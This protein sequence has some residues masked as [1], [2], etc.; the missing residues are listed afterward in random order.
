MVVW[1][2]FLSLFVLVSFVGACTNNNAGQLGTLHLTDISTPISPF[3]SVEYPVGGASIPVS[4][5]VVQAGKNYSI[6]STSDTG[7]SVICNADGE[8]IIDE[9]A[10]ILPAVDPDK[11][12]TN[13]VSVFN[14]IVFASN[15]E[16]GVYVYSF[17]N[18]GPPAGGSVCGPLTL[19][20]LGKIGFTDDPSVNTFISKGNLHS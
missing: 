3:I 14:G 7:F 4:K 15:G 11:T 1:R 13:A 17:E 12:V 20:F 10:V 9:P 19:S 2:S 8:I 5:S 6:V 18:A 16:A